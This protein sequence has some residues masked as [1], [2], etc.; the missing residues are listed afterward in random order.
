M[1][2]ECSCRKVIENREGEQT[3]DLIVGMGTST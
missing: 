3:L 1:V 2:E